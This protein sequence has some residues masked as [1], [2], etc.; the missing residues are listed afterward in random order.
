ML[1]TEELIE[2]LQE[3]IAGLTDRDIVDMELCQIGLAFFP[4]INRAIAS[5]CF[6]DGS[7]HLDMEVR[8]GWHALWGDGFPVRWLPVLTL[9]DN[10]E[11]ENVI[12][13]PDQTV[14]NPAWTRQQASSIRTRIAQAIPNAAKHLAAEANQS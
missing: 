1:K 6:V 3:A 7:W 8:E 10:S 9:L 13:F 4:R 5:P 2:I 12:R 11:I 14:D